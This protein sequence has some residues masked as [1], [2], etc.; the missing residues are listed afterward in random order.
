RRCIGVQSSMAKSGRRRDWAKV[1]DDTD[2]FP[3]VDDDPDEP[4]PTEEDDRPAESE[5]FVDARLRLKRFGRAVVDRLPQLSVA[6]VAGLALCMSFPPVGWWYLAI[7]AFAMLAW[8]LTRES[9]TF[10]GGF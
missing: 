10:A 2:I 8:P 4:S 7:A 1:T 5:R 9:T 3:A 6:I